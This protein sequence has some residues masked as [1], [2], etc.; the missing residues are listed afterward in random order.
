MSSTVVP[1]AFDGSLWTLLLM[2]HQVL[3]HHLD[4]TSLIIVLA[5]VLDLLDEG[6]DHAVGHVG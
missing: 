3:Q 4:L 5:F 2:S 6:S 1:G